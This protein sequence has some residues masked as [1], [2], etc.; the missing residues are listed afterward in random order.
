MIFADVTSHGWTILGAAIVAL[1]FPGTILAQQPYSL[2]GDFRFHKSFRSKILKNDRDVV[3]YLPPGYVSPQKR[4]YSVLYLHDG[5]NLF[6]GSTSFIPG[7][8]W[9][10]DEVAEGLID[11]GQI[12]PIIIVG[13]Y[14]AGSARNDEY[15]PTRDENYKTGGKADLYGRMLVEELKPFIDATYR[16]RKDASHTGLGGSSLGGIVS[17]YLALKYPHVF[18]KVAAVSP[19][20]WFANKQIIR[21]A[22][23]IKAKP[24]TR[25]WLDM[26]TKEGR[27]TESA[28]QAV[29]DVRLLK[30]T[31]QKKGWKLGVDLNYLEVEGAEHNETAWA[32]RVEQILKFLFPAKAVR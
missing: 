5:Q 1:I 6:D 11:S 7:K 3:V 9:R 23:A 10:V 22:E 14:N 18:G 24:K 20:V 25:I 30:E 32:A 2:T 15:T 31:L 17:L 27:T 21:Y 12:E 8:E 4:R 16:T 28:L 26:G 29:L 13:V 19:S